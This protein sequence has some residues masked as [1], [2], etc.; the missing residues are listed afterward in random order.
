M[1]E[2]IRTRNT[3]LV[4][5]W[6]H[7]PCNVLYELSKARPGVDLDIEIGGAVFSLVQNAQ[8]ARTI[9]RNREGRYDKYFGRYADLFGESRLTV[10][11]DKWRP[12]R[13]LSQPHIV[14]ANAD[15][16]AQVTQS[17]FRNVADDLIAQSHGSPVVIDDKIDLA[18]ASVISEVVLGFPFDRWGG[19]V[20]ADIR[21]ILRYAA[22]ENFPSLSES[23]VEQS[24]LVLDAEDAKVDLQARFDQMMA[25]RANHDA[26]T[27][28]NALASSDPEIIDHFGEWS[29]LLFAGFDTTASAIA[30][31]MLLLARDPALQTRL[32]AQ[33]SGI[34]HAPDLKAE[35]I[36][37][38]KD[39]S[40]FLLEAL[41]IFPPIPV[42]S[43]IAT[44]KDDIGGFRVK[45]GARVLISI[46]GVHHDPAVFPK[47]LTVQ[48]DRHPDGD[49]TKETAP[50][51]LPFGDGKRICPGAK[52]ANLEAM[53][54]LAVM[55]DKT[56]MDAVPAKTLDLR[57]EASMRQAKG[58]R[59]AISPSA[60]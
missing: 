53:T 6:L 31:A 14:G 41:R 30:W 48:P 23:S 20:I 26:Q 25:D 11:D 47:P 17:Q 8:T 56:K 9:L 28:A 2:L 44:T 36:L 38:I 22:W 58:T 29:T 59:L 45:A 33:V 37:S 40:A 54:A 51:Y 19:D 15:R 57:W 43:R 5:A 12:L 27:L 7:S 1:T 42:L 10:G 16:L 13:D 35:D 39:M 21:K 4:Q 3:P 60:R 55:L 18:A 32:R 50:H 24:F 46:I 52:I 34:A 49:L